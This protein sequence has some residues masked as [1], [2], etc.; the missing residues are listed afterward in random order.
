MLIARELEPHPPVRLTIKFR[1][2]D[3]RRVPHARSL[4]RH[5]GRQN[6]V[7][8][9]LVI[10]RRHP[11][12]LALFH[13]CR[14]AISQRRGIIRFACAVGAEFGHGKRIG[15][16]GQRRGDL[17]QIN[18]INDAIGGVSVILLQPDNVAFGNCQTFQAEFIVKISRL[19]RRRIIRERIFSI[20]P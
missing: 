13:G 14:D 6:N 18:Q 1:I 17:L 5:V 10:S 12:N 8:G 19:A 4:D 2:A 16:R 20:E 3:K 15:G 11:D 9:Q 7:S